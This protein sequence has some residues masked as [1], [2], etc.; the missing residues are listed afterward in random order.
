[1]REVAAAADQDWSS[2]SFPEGHSLAETLAATVTMPLLYDG[3]LEMPR[4]AL[5]EGIL[6]GILEVLAEVSSSIVSNMK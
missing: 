1:L 5:T 3:R 4:D 2:L 6:S